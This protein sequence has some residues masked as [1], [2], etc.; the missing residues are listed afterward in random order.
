MEIP[1][2]CNYVY[3]LNSVLNTRVIFLN[4]GFVSDQDSEHTMWFSILVSSNEFH[5]PNFPKQN[6]S[7]I[8]RTNCYMK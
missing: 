4:T 8:F 7:Y 1:L 2:I 3:T 6:T 5:W